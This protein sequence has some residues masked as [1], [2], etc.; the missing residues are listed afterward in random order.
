MSSIVE[1]IEN[2]VLKYL[3]AGKIAQEIYSNRK[4]I[5]L[6]TLDDL[7]IDSGKAV[8]IIGHMWIK[9]FLDIKKVA[10]ALAKANPIKVKK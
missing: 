9:D 7:E 1:K 6:Y 3:C 4:E 10:K 8:K 5:G 2:M